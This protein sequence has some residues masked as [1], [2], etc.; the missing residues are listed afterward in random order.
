MHLYWVYKYKLQYFQSEIIL[1]Q[2]L[3]WSIYLLSLTFEK[4]FEAHMAF[5]S[6]TNLPEYFTPSMLV[7]KSWGETN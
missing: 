4:K 1:Y 2:D 6:P 3:R 7:Q 5:I